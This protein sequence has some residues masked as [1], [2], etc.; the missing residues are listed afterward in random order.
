MNP[1]QY[2]ILNEALKVAPSIIQETF[3]FTQ[4]SLTKEYLYYYCTLETLVNGILVENPKP[5]NEVC[6]WA[7][8]W[9]HMN[10]KQE[11]KSGLDLLK[12]GQMPSTI[13]GFHE[14][15]IEKL[16]IICFTENKDK[17]QMWNGYGK[18]GYG[19]ML[20]FDFKELLKYFPNLLKPCI[21]ENTGLDKKTIKKIIDCDFSRE[22]QELSS[23]GKLIASFLCMSIF[24]SLRKDYA[25]SYEKEVRL[26]GIGLPM[27]SLPMEPKFRVQDGLIIPYIPVYFP[28]SMLK[29]IWLGPCLEHERNKIILE[30]I[31]K[32]KG[33]DTEVL[34]SEKPYR[35]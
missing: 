5:N 16:H 18:R 24:L 21:Y 2:S 22:F 34:I 7:T 14:Q 28:K 31:L 26:T 30:E 33:F 25:Y 15:Y 13:V 10:D 9:S 23:D 20:A 8:R 27:L 12:K 29:Q 35:G 17:L 32:S 6:I 3:R 11:I 4:R 19:V 1:N